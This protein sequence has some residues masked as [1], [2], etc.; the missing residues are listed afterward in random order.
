M[1]RPLKDFAAVLATEEPLFLVGGQ[2]VN[3]WALYYSERT[4]GL[5]PFVSRDVDILGNRET[6]EKIA[7]LAGVKPTFFPMRPPTNEVG[8][9]IAKDSDGQPLPVEVLSS[10]HGIKNSDL[11]TPAYTIGFDQSEILIRTPSPIALLQAKIANVA[12]LPQTDRQDEHHVR[13][14]VQLMPA[15]LS[16]IHDS[17]KDGR[18]TERDMLDLLER[19]LNIIV[20]SKG[21]TVIDKLDIS[22]REMFSE[23][24]PNTSSKIYSFINKRLVRKLPPLSPL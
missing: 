4:V 9:I 15:Y 16:D 6:L 21:N 17:V 22:G 2:A 11:Q 3:L 23:L 14:L 18:I 10:I 13:I 7:D 19:L 12:D 20:S 1:R 5:Q 24:K 8:V